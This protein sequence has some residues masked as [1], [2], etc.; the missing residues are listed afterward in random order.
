MN[1]NW[2]GTQAA[3]MRERVLWPGEDGASG[4]V[5]RLPA[6][7]YTAI[8]RSADGSKGIGLVELYD[9]SATDPA[10]LGN[11]SV[12]AGVETDDNVLF[13]GLILQGGTPK[14]V[15]F[16]GLG[17]SIPIDGALQA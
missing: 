1:L 12:R 6:G 3:D 15:V 2:H 8:I 4:I 14:R 16:R 9:L 17:P 10:E 13:D 5:K 7:N 11:L